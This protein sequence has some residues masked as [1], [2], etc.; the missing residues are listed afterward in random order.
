[1]CVYY[2]YRY[3]YYP[4]NEMNHTGVKLTI[5]VFDKTNYGIILFVGQKNRHASP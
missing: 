1:M 2:C 3:I 5:S 4:V